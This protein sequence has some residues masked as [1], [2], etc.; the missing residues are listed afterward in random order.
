VILRLCAWTLEPHGITTYLQRLAETFH[1]FY[2]KH[3]VV[4]EDVASSAARLTLVKATRQVLA[5][6]LS[7]LGVAAPRRM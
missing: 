3:R 5:N 4:T 1:V 2:T 7:I 6:G